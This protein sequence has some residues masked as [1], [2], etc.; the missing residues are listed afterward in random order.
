[1]MDVFT[2]IQYPLP[3]GNNHFVSCL[4]NIFGI[5]FFVRIFILRFLRVWSLFPI[6]KTQSLNTKPQICCKKSFWTEVFSGLF[7][8]ESLVLTVFFNR[9]FCYWFNGSFW[10]CFQTSV[11]GAWKQLETKLIRDYILWAF[12]S[13]LFLCF[14]SIRSEF[15]TRIFREE[16]TG[17]GLKAKSFWSAH[18]WDLI[19]R[20]N[21]V[22]EIF[23]LFLLLWFLSLFQTSPK[24]Q[25]QSQE[26]NRNWGG[27]EEAKLG[28]AK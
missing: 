5:H 27:G 2:G 16:M 10:K 20:Y 15:G 1:M 12:Y 18:F 11:G 14:L 7:V 22:V 25:P 6:S 26:C 8:F 21:C 4:F 23:R 24:S 28:M 19:V 9:I 13:S 17:V 3:S